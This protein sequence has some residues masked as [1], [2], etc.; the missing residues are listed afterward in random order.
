MHD[1]IINNKKAVN[2]NKVLQLIL[3]LFCMSNQK[4]NHYIN[5]LLVSIYTANNNSNFGDIKFCE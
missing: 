3:T 1:F 4:H 2:G 5:Y